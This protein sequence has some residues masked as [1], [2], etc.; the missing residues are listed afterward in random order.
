MTDKQNITNVDYEG[1]IEGLIKAG[2]SDE[3]F[4]D[5]NFSGSGLRSI[6]RLLALAGNQQAFSDNM[7]FN[8]LSIKNA[9]MRENVGAL[10][11][12]LSYVPMSAKGS[13]I[14]VDISVKVPTGYATP[15][16]DLTLEPDNTFIGIKDG[17]SYQFSPLQSVTVPLVDGYYPFKN[18]ELTQ[19][20]W[21]YNSFE[22]SQGNDSFIETYV[23]PNTDIDISTIS[24]FVQTSSTS[25]EM[26][27][28]KRYSNPYELGSD[29]K[30]FF[31]ELNQNGEYQ[32]EFGDGKLAK[33]IEYPNV[34][35]VRSM[36]TKGSDGNDI[37]SLTS[38]MPI[39]Q[40]ADV[41]LVVNSSSSNG[42]EQ[43]SIDSIKRHAPMAYGTDGLAIVA[44]DYSSVLHEKFPTAKIT[45]WGGEDNIPIMH[46]FTIIAVKPA[47][48]D[49]LTDVEKAS[50]IAFLEDR[51]VGSIWP[52]IVDAD[53]YQIN[54]TLDIYWYA[55]K[56]NLDSEGV[57][58]Y[59]TKIVREYAD[60]YLN[61]FKTEFD[62]DIMSQVLRGSD[63][64]KRVVV[65]ATFEKTIK[66]FVGSEYTGN[67]SFHK[68]IKTGTVTSSSFLYNDK[69]CSVK[70]ESGLLNIY[71]NDNVLVTEIGKVDYTLG[72]ISL[73]KLL[74]SGTT[75]VDVQFTVQPES[76]DIS[77]VSMRDEYLSI[78][79][80]KINPKAA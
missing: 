80:I 11:A 14:N 65:S 28:Y 12:F 67:I 31:L 62:P 47:S 17:T 37:G 53:I 22:V 8:E 3:T 9:E 48:A 68:P 71:D 76:N 39:G 24:V 27:E 1:L 13:I 34:V 2:Q 70:D 25:T 77:V 51:N 60:K 75:D 6:M 36:T 54:P 79:T 21:V 56:T 35:V 50:G 20:R 49:T 69:L 23:L 43:E 44:S 19:G 38:T 41:S 59:S 33:H 10:A 40:F 64:I 42:A 73:I 61:D 4:K 30:I 45:S 26:T 74:I 78:G 16:L 29:S 32:I 63:M 7:Q 72:D 55:N 52:K 58:A 66:L 46:G 57:E 5:Y 15:P 18:I